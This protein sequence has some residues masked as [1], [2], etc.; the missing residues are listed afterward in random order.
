[1]CPLSFTI[2]SFCFAGRRK[3]SDRSSRGRR[4]TATTARTA[5]TSTPGHSSAA[6]IIPRFRRGQV[7]TAPF[8]G[9]GHPHHQHPS[10]LCLLTSSPLSVSLSL[11]PPPHTVGSPSA[12]SKIHR[13]V[14][15]TRTGRRQGASCLK[16]RGAA[17]L[18]TAPS[19]TDKHSDRS[20][21]S[22]A[23]SVA[24]KGPHRCHVYGGRGSDSKSERAG[25]QKRGLGLRAGTWLPLFEERGYGALVSIEF[26]VP[27]L[28][29]GVRA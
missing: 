24:P 3:T 9:S 5:A 23:G 4:C 15:R 19:R 11:C 8:L 21:P 1:M 27:V 10:P 14:S 2:L 29:T 16:I 12:H 25:R 17:A 22:S 28:P 13:L 26:H 7:G 18:S 6:Y 20:H